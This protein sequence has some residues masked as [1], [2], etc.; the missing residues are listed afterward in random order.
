MKKYRTPCF[1]LALTM[2]LT[3]VFLHGCTPIDANGD[4]VTVYLST[5]R[6]NYDPEGK[7]YERFSWGYD[8]M[9]NILLESC[10]RDGVESY[11]YEYIYDSYGNKTMEVQYISDN[12][13]T[14]REEYKYDYDE[15]GNVIR[16]S[17]LENGKAV[18]Y[19]TYKYDERGNKIY[20]ANAMEDGQEYSYG[21][22]S[23]DDNG[24][25]IWEAHYFASDNSEK[26]EY[27]YEY[28]S[29][30]NMTLK[31]S[32]K[33]GKEID[34]SI[35]EYDKNGNW[36]SYVNQIDGEEFFRSVYEYDRK[37]NKITEIIYSQGKETKRS[38]W[39]YDI[40]GNVKQYAVY[41]DGKVVHCNDYECDKNGCIV[42]DVKT[43]TNVPQRTSTFKYTKVVI[44]R[45]QA[46]KLQAEY[47]LMDL[48]IFIDK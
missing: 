23:Y 22:F 13:V 41:Q 42:K 30:S 39:K 31:T 3:Q 7:E 48:I 32:F 35:F 21:E 6:V 44:D 33:D 15:N 8:S 29:N 25:V 2:L 19:T 40:R 14:K 11:R 5:E 10:Y 17:R 20:L 24:N 12:R 34:R 46:E 37:G 27:R 18:H 16:E 9:G 28:D 1:V 4:K 47:D 36:N 45:E 26:L 43:V 38:E